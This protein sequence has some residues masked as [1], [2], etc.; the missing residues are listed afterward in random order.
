MSWIRLWSHV[1]EPPHHRMLK[2]VCSLFKKNVGAFVL[3]KAVYDFETDQA[4]ALEGKLK[5]VKRPDLFNFA[6]K[7]VLCSPRIW[8]IPRAQFPEENEMPELFKRTQDVGLALSGGGI[9][10]SCESFGVLQAL[11][12]LGLLKEVPTHNLGVH[13]HTHAQAMHTTHCSDVLQ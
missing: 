13:T 4:L 12:S 1:A 9:R 10:A 2:S 3:V 8:T 7:G 11:H 5:D 6:V